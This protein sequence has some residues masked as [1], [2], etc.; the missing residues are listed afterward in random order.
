MILTMMRSEKA[1]YIAEIITENAM[2]SK[3]CT[4]AIFFKLCIMTKRM[5]TIIAATI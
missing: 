4:S 2:R 5:V 1:P 3:I